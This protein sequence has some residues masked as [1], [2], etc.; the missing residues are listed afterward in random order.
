MATVPDKP[1]LDG[2]EARWAISGRP[3]APTA[4][5]TRHSGRGVLDR[6]AAADGQ[7]LAARRARLLLHPHRH[8]R[9]LPAHAGPRRLL[10]DGLGRQRPAHRAPGAELL[11]R[12]L[13]PVAALRPRLRARRPAGPEASR[14][15]I[16]RPNFVELCERLTGEDEKAFE[17]LFR[18]LGSRSTGRT[19]TRPSTT[20]A[21]ARLAARVPAQPGPRR[22]LPAGGADAVGRRLPHRRRPGRAGGP[23]GARRLPPARAS[24][25]A[26]GADVSTSTPPGPSC[27]PA[28]VALVA[29]PDDE[30]YQRAVRHDGAP[31]RSSASRCRCSPTRSPTRRR[32]PASP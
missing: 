22:G 14:S 26:D 6:H 27:S 5:I 8:H 30:R 2:I 32:A 1:T 12:A 13:R 3:T 21:R 23:R 19:P 20:S 24:T 9:P 31:R 17:E 28:C 11:R 15:P 4:S 7:R 16:S 10:P 18:R 29:H 25:G